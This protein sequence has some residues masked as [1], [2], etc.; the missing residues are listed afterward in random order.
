MELKTTYN[1]YLLH[2]PSQVIIEKLNFAQFHGICRTLKEE[3]LKDF[4]VWIEELGHWQSMS[5]VFPSLLKAAGGL[6]QMHPPKNANSEE[7]HTLM[8]G[9]DDKYKNNTRFNLRLAVTLGLNGQQVHT[10]TEDVS[11]GGMKLEN[12]IPCQN[13]LDYCS[14]F[15]R[16]GP[17]A[18][19]FKACPL[20]EKNGSF[21]QRLELVS[22]TNIKFW[23]QL[24][25]KAEQSFGQTESQ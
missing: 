3:Q 8:N 10:F 25:K 16:Q 4:Q 20:F 21:F 13:R 17:D 2:I 24:I 15:F 7:A 14:V 23:R 9:P 12:S 19:E 22:C 1:F 5:E 11:L 18:V 6:F